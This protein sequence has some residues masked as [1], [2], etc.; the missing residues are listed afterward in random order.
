M[1]GNKVNVNINE[2]NCLP[3]NIAT[4][5]RGGTKSKELCMLLDQRKKVLQTNLELLLHIC[6]SQWYGIKFLNCF[7]CCR[8]E[9]ENSLLVFWGLSIYL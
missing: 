3:N 2:L 9:N 1:G 4:Q 5:G 8:S 7:M 6:F